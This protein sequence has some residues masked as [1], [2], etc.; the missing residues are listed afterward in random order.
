VRF[1]RLER[2]LVGAVLVLFVVP[3]LVAV[4]G[5]L[6]LYRRGVLDDPAA[7]AL[8]VAL[9]L[10]AMTTYVALLSHEL[11]RTLVRTIQEIQLGTELMATVN[12]EHRL[13]IRTGDD[14]QA[15]AEE[16][17]R[18]ADRVGEAR[19]GLEAEVARATA[20]L[21]VE[22]STLAAVLEALGEGVVAASA[23][24]R[25]TLANRAAQ[26]R[27][28]AG[29]VGL[30]GQ[31]LFDFVDREKVAHF[32]ERLR[33]SGGTPQRFSL[34]P[35]AGGVLEAVMTPFFDAERRIVGFVLVLRDVTSPARSDEERRARLSATFRELRGPLASVRSLAENLLDDPAA[36]TGAARPLL[37]AIHA[38]AVRLS[39]LIAGQAPA[40]AGDGTPAH[41]ERLT[42][43][44]LTAM[45]LRR[46]AAEGV[47]PE[48]LDTAAAADLPPLRAEAS[49][50]SAAVARLARAALARRAP[51]GRAWL[52]WSQ[53]GG[54]L[55]LDVG[56][57]GSASLASLEPVLDEVVPLGGASPL[58]IREVVRGHAGECWAYAGE[59]RVGFRASFPA[60]S[61]APAETPARP[62]FVGAGMASG[63]SA[64]EAVAGTRPD[65]YDFSLLDEMERRLPAA[66]RD[67]RLEDLEFVVLDTET[68]GLAPKHGDRIVSL[69]AVK[70]RGG[71][72][73]TGE[74]F[75]ALVNPRRPI[76][77]ASVGF[78]GISDAMV[79]DQPPIDVVLP[80]FLEF[81]RGAVLVG[82]QVWFDIQ[83]LA[84]EAGRLG[85]GVITDRHPVLD[86][87]ALS[88]VVHGP[89]PGHGLEEAAG[90]LGVSVRG[91]HSALGDALTTAEVLVRLLPLLARRG[92][93]TLGQALE[94]ARRARPV[95]PP[96]AGPG[97]GL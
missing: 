64:G 58:P 8:A 74:S 11:G 2:K 12:P 45:T 53:R 87:L 51:V 39:A 55:Q 92:I 82:H 31:S 70:V 6:V 33:A 1:S 97:G 90:R 60:A 23:E 49:A 16:I 88:E 67:R 7:L 14:L 85:L 95:P 25:V 4:A 27:L 28:V 52:R 29:G 84:R 73:R 37:D 78:H 69:A 3:T 10:V 96:E 65:F 81:A 48:A 35:V 89:L 72:V 44:E 71:S 18:M 5:L 38:E 79:A 77:V 40:L 15:L 41:F 20:A 30:L 22:R 34:Q 80:V 57:E 24:G 83:F 42:V 91:R 63:V 56:A 50:L 93:V 59:G 32:L 61:P 26:E 43:T 76:P 66:E 68:T 36:V 21:H 54:V 47:G 86:T 9:G 94:A 17:N 46:L 13:A 62:P 19:V 75:D